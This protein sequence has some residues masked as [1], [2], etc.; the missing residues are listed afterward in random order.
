M[1]CLVYNFQTKILPSRLVQLERTCREIMVAAIAHSTHRIYHT[2][3]QQYTK[4]CQSVD[5]NPYPASQCTLTYFVAQLV[6]KGKSHEFTWQAF[7]IITYNIPYHFQHAVRKS[8]GCCYVEPCTWENSEVIGESWSPQQ[9][10]GPCTLNCLAT[11]PHPVTT[12][13]HFGQQPLW[14]FSPVFRAM[15]LSH[16]TPNTLTRTL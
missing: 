11:K 8:Y 1:P 14:H 3:Q 12:R 4:F 2:A 9:V 6:H 15:N 13:K 5:F 16:Q 7:T 10:S